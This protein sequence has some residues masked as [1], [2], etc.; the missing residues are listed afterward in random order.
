MND[1]QKEIKSKEDIVETLELVR[2]KIECLKWLETDRGDKAQMGLYLL[3]TELSEQ[4]DSV[5]PSIDQLKDI[6]N[7][8]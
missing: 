3:M 5:L 1:T 7:A 2:D 6:Y 8:N 4:I